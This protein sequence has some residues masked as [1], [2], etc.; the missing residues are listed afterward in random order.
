M[1]IV[2]ASWHIDRLTAYLSDL[3]QEEEIT[4]NQLSDTIQSLDIDDE[5][6]RT[7]IDDLVQ[8]NIQRHRCFCEQLTQISSLL[9]N[10]FDH[11]NTLRDVCSVSK[12]STTKRTKER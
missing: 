12:T 2:W 4:Q 5:S 3:T 8:A 7:T 6:I 1:G 11:G 10:L 9:V